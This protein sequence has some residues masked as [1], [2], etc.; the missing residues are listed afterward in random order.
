MCVVLEDGNPRCR[1]RVLQETEFP[2]RR[3][4]ETDQSQETE[5]E[6]GDRGGRHRPESGEQG[7]RHR[8]ESTDQS[9]ETEAGDTDQS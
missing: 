4:R 3:R 2:D 8:P 6:S 1:A 7:R 9:Q 5:A